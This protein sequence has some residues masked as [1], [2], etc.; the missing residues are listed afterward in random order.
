MEI[1]GG[2]TI[3]ACCPIE[4]SDINEDRECTCREPYI[5]DGDDDSEDEIYKEDDSYDYD[6]DDSYDYDEDDSYDYDEDGSYNYD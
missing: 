6:E 3:K 2:A 5:V 4:C 1:G